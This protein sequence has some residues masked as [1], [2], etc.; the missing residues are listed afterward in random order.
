MD[1]GIMC[2][3][4]DQKWYLQCGIY[5]RQEWAEIKAQQLRQDH[6]DQP[7]DWVAVISIPGGWTK[8]YADDNDTFARAV[9]T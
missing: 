9:S 6:Q 5:G 7:G 1:Y 3:G 2:K 4:R 8:Q